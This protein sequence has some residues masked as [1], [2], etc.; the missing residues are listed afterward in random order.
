MQKINPLRYDYSVTLT[1]CVLI[2]STLVKLRPRTL[3]S[4][5]TRH[6]VIA[7]TCSR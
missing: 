6:G 1:Q 5:I 2:T 3:A 4:A 7:L